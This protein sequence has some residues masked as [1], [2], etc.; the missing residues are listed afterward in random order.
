MSYP[1]AKPNQVRTE[2]I[3][4]KEWMNTTEVKRLKSKSFGELKNEAIKKFEKFA[5]EYPT[6]MDLVLKEENL[7]ILI[8][9]LDMIENINGNKIDKLDGEKVIGERLAEEYLYPVVNNNM[10]R[11]N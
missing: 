1:D 2:I 7:S 3:A 5:N 8:Q 4:I 11:K 10:K 6:V 9:M